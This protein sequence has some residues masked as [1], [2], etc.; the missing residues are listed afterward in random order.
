V[1][2]ASLDACERRV[3]C[4]KWQANTRRL[5][6]TRFETPQTNFSNSSRACCTSP[7]WP[8]P[9]ERRPLRETPKRSHTRL[10]DLTNCEAKPSRHQATTKELRPTRFS[11]S[12]NAVPLLSSDTEG[13]PARMKRSI[14]LEPR[15]PSPWAKGVSCPPKFS[16]T[17]MLEPWKTA[18]QSLVEA[19]NPRT[20]PAA[21]ERRLSIKPT[22]SDCSHLVSSRHAPDLRHASPGWSSKLPGIARS[23]GPQSRAPSPWAKGVSCQPESSEQRILEPRE[24]H[25]K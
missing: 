25:T 23:M 22:P 16:E 7:T 21:G 15:S 24:T 14:G 12:L 11:M 6:T 13:K 9:S 17:G 18:H 8:P 20:S 1:Y 19:V 4:E 5:L 10:H 3:K 2:L